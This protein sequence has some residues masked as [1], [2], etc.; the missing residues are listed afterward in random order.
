VSLIPENAIEVELNTSIHGNED[1]TFHIKKT[2]QRAVN[3]VN[4]SI[5]IISS[6]I[7]LI[8]EFELMALKRYFNSASKPRTFKG[9]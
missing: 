3:C 5:F 7:L 1:Q 8:A 9:F 6:L 4:T 2:L